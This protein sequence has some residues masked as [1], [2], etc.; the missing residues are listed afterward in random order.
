MAILLPRI[1][2]LWRIRSVSNIE[3]SS[4]S[5]EIAWNLEQT[6]FRSYVSFRIELGHVICQGPTCLWIRYRPLLPGIS[7][8]IFS[9]YIVFSKISSRS[10]NVLDEFKMSLVRN[11][12]KIQKTHTQ[13]SH[14]HTKHTHL[15]HT[16]TASPPPKKDEVVTYQV[17]IYHSFPRRFVTNSSVVHHN[18]QSPKDPPHFVKQICSNETIGEED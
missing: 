6:E 11:C 15:S 10:S 14:I 8:P 16:K 3:S 2:A 18:V 17:N 5:S 13:A 7:G 12:H 4:L 9:R 1:T